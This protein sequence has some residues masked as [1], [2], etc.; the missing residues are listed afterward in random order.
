MSEWVIGVEIEIKGGGALK[1]GRQVGRGH[2]GIAK[3]MG[4]A[5]LSSLVG[6]VRQEQG[7]GNHCCG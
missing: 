3:K 5:W 6:E 7:D 2:R 1:G 4:A